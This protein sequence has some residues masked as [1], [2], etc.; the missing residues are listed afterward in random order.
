MAKKA[1][2]S[3]TKAPPAPAYSWPEKKEKR[4]LFVDLKP[5]ELSEASRRLA[6]T[7]P[8]IQQLESAMKASA[9]QHKSGIQAV[10]VEQNR[11]SGLVTQK[12]E[13]R[14]VECEWIYECSGF[15]AGTGNKIFHPE[16]KTLIRLDTGK[17]VEV[18]DILQD[19]RQMSL[20][21]DENK[22]DDEE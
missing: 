19:E 21:P 9:A 2:A 17:V 11:L 12:K 7:V 8:H 6:E 22:N 5:D 13:E 20:L 1:S 14:P 10:E 16:K 4:H 15:D 3:K 18:R